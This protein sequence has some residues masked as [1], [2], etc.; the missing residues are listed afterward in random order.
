M[1][2][3]LP[4]EHVVLSGLVTCEHNGIT[5][6]VDYV[7]DPGNPSISYARCIYYTDSS[8]ASRWWHGED[9]GIL[10]AAAREI[11]RQLTLRRTER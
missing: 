5:W 9:H 2:D 4:N 3:A 8:G 6:T 10:R 7:R 11:Q 1:S